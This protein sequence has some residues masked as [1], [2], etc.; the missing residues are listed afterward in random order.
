[1][2]KICV[3]GSSLVALM[4]CLNGLVA[5]KARDRRDQTSEGLRL[6]TQML[7]IVQEQYVAEPAPKDLVDNAIKGILR[8][9]DP[10][11]SFMDP[12]SYHEMEIETSGTFGGIGIETTIRDGILTIVSALEG[13]PAFRAGLRSGDRI[14]TIDGLATKDMQISDA[15]THLRGRPGTM[16]T[17]S[18]ERDG[19]TEPHQYTLQRE[20]IRVQSI[21]AQE[22][23]D[24]V[25]Y[26]KL[27]EFQERSS[28]DM[29]AALATLSGAGM[30]ML[31]LDLRD[32]PGGLLVAAVEIAE[33]FLDDGTLIV[34]TEGRALDQNMRFFAHPGTSYA[35]VPLVV[36]VNEG[37]ASA[38]EIVA[39]ALQDWGRATIVGTRSFGKGSVQTIIP[40]SDGSALRLTTARYFTPKGRSIHGRGITPDIVVEV[41]KPLAAA[42][43]APP[44]SDSAPELTNDAQF[45]TAVEI[46]KGRSN[47][48]PRLSG[49]ILARTG[50]LRREHRPRTRPGHP[51]S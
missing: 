28:Q 12:D 29:D 21:Q 32:D 36:L 26:I 7:S 50:T 41:P 49:R 44:V 25:G 11:S 27:R 24:G 40:L 16:A 31:V 51:G 13:T 5:G 43:A 33:K 1:M 17:L 22:V 37:T 14:I 46:L 10:H 39:G 9:L 18:V 19:W 4:L 30:R 2:K 42:D 3:I 38:S 45:K 20:Q 48:G 35:N 34:Y 8:G 47:R 15:V 23:G 6:F